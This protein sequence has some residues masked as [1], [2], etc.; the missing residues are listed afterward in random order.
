MACLLNSDFLSFLKKNRFSSI[1]T[2]LMNKLIEN[3]LK[4][5]IFSNTLYF[6]FLMNKNRY[7]HEIELLCE[8]EGKTA[9]IIFSS[10]KK[11]YPNLWIWTVYRNLTT[12]VEEGILVKIHGLGDRVIYEKKQD[13]WTTGHL[14]C[15]NSNKII[16]VNLPDINCLPL[17]LPKDFDVDRVEVIFYG[18]FKNCKNQCKGKIVVK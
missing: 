5:D 15:E 12:L 13:T 14:V 11:D 9:D 4:R 16:K 2:E 6:I 3:I 7:K 1:I 10:L 18:K 17:D 8:K